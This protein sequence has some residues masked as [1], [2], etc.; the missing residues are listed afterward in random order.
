MVNPTQAQLAFQPGA[1]P[2]SLAFSLPP[3]LYGESGCG[4]CSAAAAHL[5]RLRAPVRIVL[6]APTRES[7]HAAASWLATLRMTFAAYAFGG[8]PESQCPPKMVRRA[9]LAAPALGWRVRA[10]HAGAY[11]SPL[12]FG[13]LRA[14]VYFSGFALAPTLRRSLGRFAGLPLSLGVR[15]PHPPPAFPL[16]L[17][18]GERWRCRADGRRFAPHFLGS[19]RARSAFPRG[20]PAAMGGSH[21]RSRPPRDAVAAGT[22]RSPARSVRRRWCS[23]PRYAWHSYALWGYVGWVFRLSSPLCAS[24]LRGSLR[25]PCLYRGRCPRPVCPSS[26]WALLALSGFGRAVAAFRRINLFI[27]CLCF[28]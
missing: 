28:S 12:C 5:C 24:P 9:P 3:L 16:A 7:R 13:L 21:P 15:H 4:S 11:R 10:P 22:P 2:R 14:L 6:R 23:L 19:L 20:Q 8:F 1:A 26:R 27:S 17:A 25:I 18:R